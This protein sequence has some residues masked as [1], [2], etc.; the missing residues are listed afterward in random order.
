MGVSQMSLL[1]ENARITDGTHNFIKHWENVKGNHVPSDISCK[2]IDLSAI[3]PVNYMT[4][5]FKKNTARH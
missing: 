2:I 5:R 4:Y 1:L 3:P